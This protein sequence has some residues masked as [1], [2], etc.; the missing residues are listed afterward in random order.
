MFQELQGPKWKKEN[1]IVSFSSGEHQREDELSEESHEA[2]KEG[3]HAPDSLA[4]WGPPYGASASS[5]LG[6][7]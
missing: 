5:S 2:Q 4:A 7:F 1:Y 6:D 3:A